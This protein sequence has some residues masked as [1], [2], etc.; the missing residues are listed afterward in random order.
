MTPGPQKLSQ[1]KYLSSPISKTTGSTEANIVLVN[2]SIKGQLE[3]IS[4]Y[5]KVNNDE[6]RSGIVMNIG[7]GGMNMML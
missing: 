5:S 6:V 1:S 2:F 7:C 4:S 3:F